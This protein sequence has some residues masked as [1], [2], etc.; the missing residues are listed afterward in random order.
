MLTRLDVDHHT[1]PSVRGSSSLSAAALGDPSPALTKENGLMF[2]FRCSF[3]FERT[4]CLGNIFR[5]LR[6]GGHQACAMGAE[7]GAGR[8]RAGPRDA[9]RAGGPD[10]R[11][12]AV[13]AYHPSTL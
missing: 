13:R 5:A 11:G 4:A 8:S 7:A 10:H 1:Q 3:S 6:S 12:R 2:L 9:P